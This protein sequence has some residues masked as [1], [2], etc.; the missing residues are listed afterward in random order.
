[1]ATFSDSYVDIAYTRPLRVMV[2]QFDGSLR[3]LTS[4]ETEHDHV[5]RI[6]ASDLRD[7]GRRT[8]TLH[9]EGAA[10]GEDLTV[11]VDLEVMIDLDVREAR[12]MLPDLDTP[13]IPNSLRYVGTS[14]G[15]ASLI[16]DIHALR[17]TDGVTLLPM[18]K[19]VL[20]LILS[21]ALPVL[22]TM[23]F[24]GLTGKLI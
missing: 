13:G 16:A 4:N 1:M 2:Q 3:D 9:A 6:T 24:E 19:R 5:V 14:I 10:R 12:N 22:E 17:L 18:T 20:G 23:D 11:V 15:L 7:A 8:A 21:E